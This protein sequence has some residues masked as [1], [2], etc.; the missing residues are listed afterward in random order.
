MELCRGNGDCILSK[1]L[2]S[3]PIV[4]KANCAPKKCL[5]F[6]VCGSS[7]LNA[8]IIPNNLCFSCDVTFRKPLEFINITECHACSFRGYGA[9]M[10]DSSHILCLKCISKQYYADPRPGP[11]YPYSEECDYNHPL[12]IKYQKEYDEW[13]KLLLDDFKKQESL[14]ICRK[15]LIKD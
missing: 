9:V 10:P 4:C 1:Q 6:V 7:Q 12:L 11:A 15:C 8:I 5:N 2:D 13:T 14:R 3:S